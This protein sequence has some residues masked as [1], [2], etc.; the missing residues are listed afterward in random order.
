LLNQSEQEQQWFKPPL[1]KLSAR[2]WC[3]HSQVN[4]GF[5]AKR[6]GNSKLS[7]SHQRRGKFKTNLLAPEGSYKENSKII[8]SIT[9]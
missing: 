7:H 9:N 1:Y 4:L 8:T 2:A 3:H 5:Q 6:G